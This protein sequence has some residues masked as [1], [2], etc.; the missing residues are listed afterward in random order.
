MPLYVYYPCEGSSGSIFTSNVNPITPLGGQNIS[1]SDLPG[2]EGQCYHIGQSNAIPEPPPDVTIDWSS[3]AYSLYPTCEICVET[4]NFNPPCLCSTATNLDEVSSTEFR[5]INCEGELSLYPSLLPGETGPKI[6]LRNWEGSY[7]EGTFQY[8]GNCIDGDCP[9]FYLLTDCS[10]SENTFCTNTDLSDYVDN[11]IS[12]VLNGA[13]YSGKCWTVTTAE[14]CINPVVVTVQFEYLNCSDC[15]NQFVTNYKLTNC[16]NGSVIYTSTDLSQT[17]PVVQIENYIDDCWFV[18]VLNTNI[19]SDTPVTVLESFADCPVCLATYYILED[20]DT[21]STVEPIITTTNLEAFVGQVITLKTCP[22]ICWTVNVTEYSPNTQDVIIQESFVTC[23]LCAQTQPGTCVT[24]TNTNNISVSI[25]Y[26]D[27]TGKT[28][29]VDIKANKTSSK[30][31]ALSWDLTEGVTANTFGDCVD[32]LCPETPQP[33]RKVTPGYNTPVCSTDYYEK[34]ECSFSE[35]MYKDVLQKRY[36]ISNCC[37][38]ELTKWLIKHEMLMLDILLN[39]DYECV[40]TSTC[41]CSQ[42]CNCGYIN[43]AISNRSCQS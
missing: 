43:T 26:V 11:G 38:E 30:V 5:Y 3:Q 41:G 27:L 1:F 28:Q 33:K 37:P 18:E 32:G 25:N 16:E 22:E 17:G 36:G 39:P 24:F 8:Y 21:E 35:W 40:T 15:L 7:P 34:V 6:C 2:Y 10:D 4:Q 42:V 9:G 14:E 13:E 23:I 12:I 19:P 31:C 29:K 20:C